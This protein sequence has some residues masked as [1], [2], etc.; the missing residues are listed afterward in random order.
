MAAPPPAVQQHPAVD[1]MT[2]KAAVAIQDRPVVPLSSWLTDALAMCAAT[3]RSLQVLTPADARVT[4]PLRTVLQNPNARW[5]VEEPD[6]SGHFDGFSGVPLVWD[7]RSGFVV[8]RARPEDGPSPTFRRPCSDPGSQLWID[9]RLLRKPR[10]DLLLGDS[11]EYLAEVFAEA[12]PAGWGTSE[13]ALTPWDPAALT[14]LGRRRSPQP[15]W[16]VFTGPPVAAHRFLGTHRT[17]RVV[18][19]VKETVVFTVGYRRDEEPALHLL[20][21]VAGELAERG[22]LKTM[23]VQ[24]LAGRP[25]LTYEPLWSG[26]PVPVGVAV[27]PDTVAEIGTAHADSAPSPGER[28]GPSHAPALW[29][30]LGDGTDPQAWRQFNALMEHLRPPERGRPS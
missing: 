3:N 29:Y 5:V 28:V 7:E 14:A 19:G 17:T 27:G 24:R 15:T 22:V 30:P 9:L 6:G 2:D 1:V 26:P 18:E 11:V 4:L 20:G 25:D 23:T 12:D 16:T 21:R 13:P 10:E 8:R